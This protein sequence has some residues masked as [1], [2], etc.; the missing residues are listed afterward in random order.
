MYSQGSLNSRRPSISHTLS[1]YRRDDH[2]RRGTALNG[3]GDLTGLGVLGRRGTG[4]GLSLATSG[5]GF[6]SF[7]TNGPLSPMK[8]RF[9]RRGL[10]LLAFL[11]H[12]THAMTFHKQIQIKRE[13]HTGP[14]SLHLVRLDLQETAMRRRLLPAGLARSTLEAGRPL[15][16][17][18][19]EMGGEEDAR[20]ELWRML[21][22][23]RINVTKSRKVTSSPNVTIRRVTNSLMRQL[24]L[25][26]WNQRKSR[27]TRL[28][29]LRWTTGRTTPRSRMT[30]LV[31]RSVLTR[32][33]STATAAVNLHPRF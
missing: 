33:S 22:E 5:K 13:R 20:L 12:L 24:S 8:D 21:E 2:I 18:L 29:V 1:D 30:E 19:L 14:G 32:R 16:Y 6:G 25:S 31:L 11:V 27:K 10:S 26:P 28:R 23:R 4:D 15:V 9:A 7:V 3:D 17:S